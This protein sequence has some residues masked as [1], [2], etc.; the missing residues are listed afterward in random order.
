[1][2]SVLPISCVQTGSRTFLLSPQEF[3][4]TLGSDSFSH[5][6]EKHDMKLLVLLLI[7]AF[8]DSHSLFSRQV[9]Q[10]ELVAELINQKYTALVESKVTLLNI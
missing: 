5:S 3:L 6:I 4:D 7:V 10:R 2:K 8:K 9:Q 1:M